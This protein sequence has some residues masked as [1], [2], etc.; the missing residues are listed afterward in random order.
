MAGREGDGELGLGLVG[1]GRFGTFL[2]ESFA[3]LPGLQLVAVADGDLARAEAAAAASGVAAYA[4]VADLVADDRVGVVAV[5]TPPASHAPVALAA[6]AAGKHVFCEKP[7][8]TDLAQA[9]GV[10]RAARDRDV[11]LTVDYVL[12]RNPLYALLA[13]LQADLLGPL[14]RFALENLAGD[15]QLGPD[16][17]FWDATVSGGILV[18][19]G[20]H[21]FDACSWLAGAEPT[22]VQALAVERA[23]GG[24]VDTVV[25]SAGYP[26]GASATF[27]HVFARPNAAELQRTTLDW[28]FAHGV[29]DGW[30]PVELHL[31][32]WTDEHGRALLDRVAADPPAALAVPGYRPSGRER[33]ATSVVATDGLPAVWRGRGRARRVAHH[34]RAHASLG[35]PEATTGVYRESVRAGMA[36]LLDA[37]AGRRPPVVTPADAWRSLA[38]ALAA[39]EAAAG[40]GLVAPA[41][42]PSDLTAADPGVRRAGGRLSGWPG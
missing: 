10:L 6:I 39:R 28:G 38:V 22:M 23:P 1:C 16:H 29:L 26:G 30:V 36:D 11:R 14:Q 15:E 18:E 21:F 42:L 3:G 40:G 37:A 12:R 24:P 13:R 35:G 20:V 34:V 27:A 32:V 17:W 8:A 25:A 31:D 33:L 2:L 41:P 5:T 7:L 4:D 9:T 19:H